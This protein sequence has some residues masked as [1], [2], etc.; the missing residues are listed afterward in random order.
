MFIAVTLTTGQLTLINLNEVEQICFSEFD[1]NNSAIYF[2]RDPV[3][4]VLVLD[5]MTEIVKGLVD[6][7]QIC[8]PHIDNDKSRIK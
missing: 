6:A 8:K 4:R 1:I 5:S 3:S 2:K 7:G